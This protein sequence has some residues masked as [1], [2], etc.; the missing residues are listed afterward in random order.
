MRPEV[1]EKPKPLLKSKN[2]LT[3]NTFLKDAIKFEE[4]TDHKNSS[5]SSSSSDKNQNKY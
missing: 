1:K 3:P 4:F 2:N 5:K